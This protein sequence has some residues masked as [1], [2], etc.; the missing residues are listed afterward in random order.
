MAVGAT[1][2]DPCRSEHFRPSKLKAADHLEEWDGRRYP[3]LRLNRPADAPPERYDA[4]LRAI[5]GVAPG[6]E[7]A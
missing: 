4:L 1:L 5:L 2:C 7:V 6:Q 3:S